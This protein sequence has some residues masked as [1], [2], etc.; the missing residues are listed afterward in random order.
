[1]NN[2]IEN[3]VVLDTAAQTPADLSGFHG[4]ASAVSFFYLP[5]L[6]LCPH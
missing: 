6:L 4:T 3:P 2:A 5:R 1:M